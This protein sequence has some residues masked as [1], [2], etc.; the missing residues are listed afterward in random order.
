[1]VFR[2]SIKWFLVIGFCASLSFGCASV[3][4]PDELCTELY[5][6]SLFDDNCSCPADTELIYKITDPKI[7]RHLRRWAQHPDVKKE[8]KM[9]PN[10]RRL[11]KP[12]SALRVQ[13]CL[14]SDGIPHGPVLYTGYG[15]IT[16]GDPEAPANKKFELLQISFEH[17][18]PTRVIAGSRSEALLDGALMLSKHPAQ[19]QR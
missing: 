19:S 11:V 7:A 8:R 6:W 15:A 5:E 1:M 9:K 4:G 2:R 10:E 17:G 13:A 14:K 16:K 18:K 12:K 3:E